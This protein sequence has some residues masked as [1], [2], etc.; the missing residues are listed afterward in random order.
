MIDIHS[1]IIFDV[2]DGAQDLEE[3]RQMLEAASEAGVTTLIATPHIRR[4]GVDTSLMRRHADILKPMAKELGINL[5]LGFECNVSTFTSGEFSVARRF[6]IEGS[7]AL[8]LEY[9]FDDWPPNWERIIYGLQDEGLGIIIAHP[10]RY[11]PIRR[12]I[13]IIDRI[14]EMGCYLQVNASSLKGF[15]DKRKVVQYI[16]K[17]G[18]LDYIASDAHSAKA[19]TELKKAIRKLKNDRCLSF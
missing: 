12:D 5:R 15:G 4:P 6:C 16:R 7:S 2:D 9:P 8:L 13:S 18:R 1:H 3:S 14:I 10:E 19:Y 11:F 17:L